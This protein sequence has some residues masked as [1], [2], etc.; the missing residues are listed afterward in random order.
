MAFAINF[1]LAISKITINNDLKIDNSRIIK[2][3]DNK[4][5]ELHNKI[6]SSKIF[7]YNNKFLH[8]F[9]QTNNRIRNWTDMV[10][11]KEDSHKICQLQYLLIVK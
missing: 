1:N 2:I 8:K 3:V 9:K 11:F 4:E 10:L 6:L 7:T 5:A